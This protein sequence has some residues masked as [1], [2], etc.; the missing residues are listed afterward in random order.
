MD[1]IPSTNVF[2][3]GSFQRLARM[4]SDSKTLYDALTSR[5]ESLGNAGEASWDRGAVVKWIQK[6]EENLPEVR[7]SVLELFITSP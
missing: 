7:I 2:F 5:S 1:S 4:I 3:A 6:G